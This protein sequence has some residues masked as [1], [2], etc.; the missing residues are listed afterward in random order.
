MSTHPF[1]RKAVK[2]KG[3]RRSALDLARGRLVLISAVFSLAYILIAAR[4]VDLSLIQGELQHYAESEAVE[5]DEETGAIV[6]E[7]VRRA[8]ILD[9]NGVLLA[10]SLEMASL[11]ADPVMVADPVAVAEGLVRVFPDMIYGDMLQKLQ[12]K[13]RF[14]WLRRNITP[15]EQYGVLELGQPGLK[16]EKGQRRIY[17]Q[18][19]LAAHFIGYTNIDGKGLAGV[20]RSFDSFL[21]EA[22]GPLALTLDIRLQYI[23]S[24]EIRTAFEK[25]SAQGAVGVVLDITNGEILAATSLP[26][27][28]PHDPGGADQKALFN[29]LTLGV[30]ELGS[31]FKIFSTAALLETLDV[32]MG[33]TFDARKPL[34]HGRFHISDFH[35]EKRRLTVPEVFVYSSNIGAA[36]MGEMVGTEALKDF[37]KD[38]GLFSS[39]SLEIGEIGHP[40]LPET[41]RDINTL[42]ASYGHGIAVSP[43]QMVVAA[44]TI[45][46]GGTLLQPTLILDKNKAEKPRENLDLRVVS[47]QTAHRLRQLM[48]L[49]VTNGTGA[50]ADVP[51]Y[52]VGGK[53]GTAEKPGPK[54]YDRKRL[55]SSFI[56]FFPM[57]A[58]RYA[59]FVML[60]E[61]KGTKDSFNYATG[62]WVAAPAVGRIIASMGPLLGVRP[63]P[64]GTTDD[65]AVSL[66]HY[67]HKEEKKGKKSLASY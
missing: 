63:L 22:A 59:V 38:L 10:T 30:Y 26:S 57:E 67:L 9:R 43:L 55:L 13:S 64:D 25:F 32:P 8:D 7:Q 40:I 36:L 52:R 48:R 42:T 46:G 65:L 47:P 41:W 54:G 49:T 20:E 5:S 53:T 27:F 11:Y 33:K 6:E 24:R 39:L 21:N 28:D 14:V 4:V 19:M 29:R 51:G 61:P 34:K 15:Q 12:R 2:I 50:K 3:S 16:F 45:M 31:P 60:D 37:Y 44:S 18:G 35:P 62:G 58:P 56:G 23:L 66:K 1:S 17:P